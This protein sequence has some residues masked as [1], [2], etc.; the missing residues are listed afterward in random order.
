MVMFELIPK[1]H[2]VSCTVQII[3][4]IF[5]IGALSNVLNQITKFKKSAPINLA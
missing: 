5:V 1:T 4:I 3:G 2:N